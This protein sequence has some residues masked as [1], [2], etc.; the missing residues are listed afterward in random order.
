MA[1]VSGETDNELSDHQDKFHVREDVNTHVPVGV[2]APSGLSAPSDG[3][4]PSGV[5]VA[6]DS[7]DL[8]ALKETCQYVTTIVSNLQQQ[9]STLNPGAQQ[10]IK[11]L[12]THLRSLVMEPP[13][14]SGGLDGKPDVRAKA[15]LY[16]STPPTYQSDSSSSESAV[17]QP[18]TEKRKSRHRSSHSSI[19]QRVSSDNPGKGK[20]LMRDDFG[21]SRGRKSALALSPDQLLEVLSRMDSRTVPKPDKFDMVTGQS[22]TDFLVSFEEYCSNTFRGSSS[23]WVSE[24]GRFL[25]GTIHDAYLAVRTPNDSFNSI[26]R[27]LTKWCSDTQEVTEKDTRRRFERAKMQPQDSFRL[28]AAQL[29]KAFTLAHPSRDV[30]NSG[31]LRRKFMETVPRAFRKQ[32]STARSLSLTMHNRELTWSNILSLASRQDAEDEVTGTSCEGEESEVWFNSQ[33]RSTSVSYLPY[34]VDS[35]PFNVVQSSL[36]L[37]APAWHSGR[38][39]SARNNFESRR[40]PQLVGSQEIVSESRTCYYCNRAGHVKADC[41]RFNGLCLVCGSPSHQI[42]TCPQRRPFNYN[43]NVTHDSPTLNRKVTFETDNFVVP[44]AQNNAEQGVE[45]T[46]SSG[47]A[48][49]YR[50]PRG[51][52]TPRRS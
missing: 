46:E 10:C 32:L 23:L 14:G 9:M 20:H 49:N 28:Y 44:S 45:L 2:S 13:V 33:P 17:A 39:P 52:G 24:L 50:A 30:E 48:L 8:K 41:R 29:E 22:F 6:F 36:N 31:S 43:A 19:N 5:S 1:S 47:P 12:N 21:G 51:R 3:A 42:S 4:G 11:D 15:K 27:K 38:L 25:S 18:V 35:Q 34:T 26:K 40:S 37:S 7:G 16:K